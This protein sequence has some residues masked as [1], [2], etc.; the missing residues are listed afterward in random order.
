MELQSGRVVHY[1]F[2]PAEED[3]D[4]EA[5]KGSQFRFFSVASDL[6]WAGMR[7]LSLSENAFHFINLCASVK[8]SRLF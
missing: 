5:N 8:L 4:P 7:H 2:D 6:D 1:Y 3:D